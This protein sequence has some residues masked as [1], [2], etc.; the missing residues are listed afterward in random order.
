MNGSLNNDGSLEFQ[1]TNLK[2]KPWSER[3]LKS[4]KVRNRSRILWELAM[5]LHMYLVEKIMFSINRIIVR[6]TL[7]TIS[8]FLCTK[9]LFSVEDWSNLSNLSFSHKNI[10]LGDQIIIKW[11]FN[12]VNFCNLFSKNVSHLF[13]P[14]FW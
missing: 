4:L 5:K 13:C 14:W 3:K 12:F 9:S 7:S 1:E 10:W 6:T 11:N 2:S 8:M